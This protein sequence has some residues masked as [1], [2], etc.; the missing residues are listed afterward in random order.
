M[1][2][3]PF[4]TFLYL[5]LK[6]HLPKPS[7]L[8]PFLCS[9]AQCGGGIII[10]NF[11]HSVLFCCLSTR[12]VHKTDTRK[13][14]EFYGLCKQVGCQVFVTMTSHIIVFISIQTLPFFIQGLISYCHVKLHVRNSLGLQAAATTTTTCKA[15]IK[16]CS[17]IIKLLPL[18]R[19]ET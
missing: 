7:D 14:D 1:T 2:L 17:G 8:I 11:F 15:N 4:L 12:R 19:S 18:W 9:R 5:W 10:V 3:S 6:Y 13:V 16:S